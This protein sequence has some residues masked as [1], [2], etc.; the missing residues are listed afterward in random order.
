MPDRSK[1]ARVVSWILQLAAVF[2][3]GQSLFFKFTGAPETVALF[4]VL[5]A[6]PWGRYA[7]ALAE[8][9]AVVLLLVPR[10]ITIG[11]ILALGVITGA[12]LSHLTKLGVS[13]DPEALGNP[14]LQPLAGPT[15]FVMALVVFASSLAVL[16]VRRTEIPVIGQKLASGGGSG[17]S[18]THG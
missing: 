5:G 2:I 11:A 1:N 13:I 18:A 14:D 9:A 4:E 10:T 12:I 6:E 15:L 7:T 3:L 16:I 17:A 8:L